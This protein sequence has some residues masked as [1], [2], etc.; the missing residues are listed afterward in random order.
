[1]T[2][3][4]LVRHA[5]KTGGD[6]LAGR[7]PGVHLTAHGREQA[8]RLAVFLASGRIDRI[9]TSPLERAIETAAPLGEAKRLTPAANVALD[10]MNLGEWTG[11]KPSELAHDRTFARFN[12][13]RSGTAAPGGET[14][15]DVQARV[16]GAML[17]WRDEHPADTLV[18]V[19]HAEPIRAALLYFAGAALDHWARFSIDVGAVCTVLL[20]RDTAIVTR[21]NARPV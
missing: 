17:R 14:M 21:V 15:L 10:E 19:T 16:V 4:H 9:F 5:E 11:K 1:M 8:Q 20:D 6:V 3:F 2:T 18:L 7:T 12:Q 13:F